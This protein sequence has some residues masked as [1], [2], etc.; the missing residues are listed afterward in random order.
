M[1]GE[2]QPQGWKEG[3]PLLPWVFALNTGE[4]L[5]PG[6]PWE[7]PLFATRCLLEQMKESESGAFSP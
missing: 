2:Q 1:L 7:M 3:P 4:Q 5:I 6:L